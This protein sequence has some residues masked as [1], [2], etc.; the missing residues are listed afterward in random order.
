VRPAVERFRGKADDVLMVKFFDNL[1]KRPAQVIIFPDLEVPSPRVFGEPRHA[2]VQARTL[3]ADRVDHEA[4]A[5][6]MGLNAAVARRHR[7]AESSPSVNSGTTRRPARRRGADI[8]VS[9]ASQA[10]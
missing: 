8:A 3:E 6:G 7:E 4:A 5:L 1:N 2:A 10:G 9:V